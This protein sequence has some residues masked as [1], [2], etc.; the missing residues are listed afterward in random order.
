M[1][2]VFTRAWEDD[3]LDLEL[4][5]V[6]PGQRALVVAGAGDTALALAAGGGEIWAVDANRDQLRLCALKQ[7]AWSLPPDRRHVWFEAGRGP[8]IRED[9]RAMVRDRLATGR[10]IAA[11]APNSRGQP[12]GRGLNRQYHRRALRRDLR[13]GRQEARLG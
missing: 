8:G 1:A 5:A 13:P 7:A 6:G 10:P 12:G 4:L 3:Q 9:Y 2:I 11:H